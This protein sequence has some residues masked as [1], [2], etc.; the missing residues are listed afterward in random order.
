MRV[1]CTTSAA[2]LADIITLQTP[3]PAELQHSSQETAVFL[4]KNQNNKFSSLETNDETSNE[5]SPDSPTHSDSTETTQVTSITTLKNK[6]NKNVKGINDFISKNLATQKKPGSFESSI[7][8]ADSDDSCA[9]KAF[10]KP[11]LPASLSSSSITHVVNS[12]DRLLSSFNFEKNRR[13]SSSLSEADDDQLAKFRRESIKNYKGM[14]GVSWGSLSI[15]AWLK[16]EIMFNKLQ[17][18][19]T[20]RLQQEEEQKLGNTSTTDK[21]LF[22]SPKSDDL[23]STLDTPPALA[24]QKNDETNE[25]TSKQPL[26]SN[27]KDTIEEDMQKN[28][29]VTLNQMK[30]NGSSDINNDLKTQAYYLP[31]L[32]QK[33]CKDYSCC[34]I[35]LPSLHDL[36]NHYE[37]S[38]VPGSRNA[39]SKSVSDINNKNNAAEIQPITKQQSLASSGK[40]IKSNSIAIG[41]KIEKISSYKVFHNI[42]NKLNL[43][44]IAELMPSEIDSHQKHFEKRSFQL[45]VGEEKQFQKQHIIIEDDDNEVVPK[46]NNQNIKFETIKLQ[47]GYKSYSMS[48]LLDDREA[49]TNHMEINIKAATPP[50]HFEAFSFVSS[51]KDYHKERTASPQAISKPLSQPDSSNINVHSKTNESAVNHKATTESILEEAKALIGNINTVSMRGS[52]SLDLN[53]SLKTSDNISLDKKNNLQNHN[54]SKR[55]SDIFVSNLSASEKPKI[56]Q[57]NDMDDHHNLHSD[58]EIDALDEADLKVMVELGKITNGRDDDDDDDN[59]GNNE[60]NHNNGHDDERNDDDNDD[61][62]D[63]DDEDDDE[64]KE[65]DDEDLEHEKQPPLKK[66]K[67]SVKSVGIPDEPFMKSKKFMEEDDKPFRCPVIGCDKAYKNQNGLKYHRAHGHEGQILQENSDGTFSV[68]NPETNLPFNEFVE[69]EL[70]KPYR[71]DGCGRRYKNLNGL[72]YHKAHSTH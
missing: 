8:S 72:K 60:H 13:R 10:T 35:S 49:K 27:T 63:D 55:G 29:S 51:D 71:C 45:T 32:E 33:Y 44:T 28:D 65:D 6:S 26:Q 31:T 34:G 54:I 9:T 64:E 69:F 68:I 21:Y 12:E 36:L 46:S 53:L 59:H 20:I 67:I 43:K 58:L 57:H 38:H 70:D 23:F 42:E 22:N 52:K 16:D 11:N 15:G 39:E 30:K 24:K 66:R 25:E 48:D 1:C 17:D 56:S 41:E 4:D 18:A 5:S 61:I 37:E 14:G 47:R 3:E 19:I 7:I 40:A 50:P 62:N 2:A